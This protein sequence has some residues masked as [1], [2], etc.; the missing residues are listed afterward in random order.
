MMRAGTLIAAFALVA[1][2][3]A[4]C[5]PRRVSTAAPVPPTQVV[6]LTE[7]GASAPGRAVVSSSGG[8]VELGANRA[9][10]T[11]LAGRVPSP[12]TV[13]P[14]ATVAQAFGPVLDTLPRAPQS[15]TLYFRLE[16]NELT[17]ESRQLLPGVLGAITSQ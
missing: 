11:V 14:E 1:V 10:T 2:A 8:M 15:F 6:L 12:S 17:E 4:G 5:G 7:P 3:V 13:L 9:S 16:S